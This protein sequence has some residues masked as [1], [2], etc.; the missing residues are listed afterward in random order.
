MNPTTV[1]MGIF[2][3]WRDRIV[4]YLEKLFESTQFWRDQGL[5]SSLGETKT[6]TCC[7]PDDYRI[8]HEDINKPESKQPWESATY[9]KVV[10]G[11][12]TDRGESGGFAVFEKLAQMITGKIFRAWWYTLE[13]VIYRGTICWHLDSRRSPPSLGSR[14]DLDGHTYETK[15]ITKNGLIGRP[16]WIGND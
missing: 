14:P 10:R 4:L 11:G 13:I 5:G 16:D 2:G 8:V 12:Q 7:S 6:K 9:S 3:S 1:S 15:A